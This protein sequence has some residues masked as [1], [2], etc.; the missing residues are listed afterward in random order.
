MP[1]KDYE[2]PGRQTDPSAGSFASSHSTNTYS[3]PRSG[4]ISNVAEKG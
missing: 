4:E 2:T 1:T 3:S